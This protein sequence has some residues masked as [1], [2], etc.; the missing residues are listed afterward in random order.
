MENEVNEP[1]QDFEKLMNEYRLAVLACEDP[2]IASAEDHKPYQDREREA[3]KALTA[4]AS[5]APA[6]TDAEIMLRGA[7]AMIEAIERVIPRNDTDRDYA[8]TV[9]QHVESQA[10]F[11]NSA[12]GRILDLEE[13]IKGLRRAPNPDGVA[14]V[15]AVHRLLGSGS[16]EK[17]WPPGTPDWE[18]LESYVAA[19]IAAIPAPTAKEAPPGL[20]CKWSYDEN[21][22][23]DTECGHNFCFEEDGASENGAK[24][25]LYCGGALIEVNRS[26]AGPRITPEDWADLERAK[27]E[28]AE[29]RES[30]SD[31]I[32][33]FRR[34]VA[35]PQVEGE[36][37]FHLAELEA[38]RA[39]MCPD[40]CESRLK[41][42]EKHGPYCRVISKAIA[43]FQTA[44]AS[45]D[46][47]TGA[48][49]EPLPT[50]DGGPY[51]DELGA[52]TAAPG[53]PGFATWWESFNQWGNTYRYRAEEEEEYRNAAMAAWDAAS[54][55]RGAGIKPGLGKFCRRC[56]TKH[57]RVQIGPGSIT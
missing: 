41:N 45:P 9:R 21:G 16:D 39:E 13:E 43:F 37:A 19:L 53:R 8:D 10:A 15:D 33:E 6:P 46:S 56:V 7:N 22:P 48:D 32:P 55:A 34:P 2:E 38:I 54:M 3:R 24:F 57:T 35:G 51:H 42:S 49:T 20:T 50:A 4:F 11:L 28:M 14:L 36:K 40:H 44:A 31:L 26:V 18:A 25:C 5:Q 12:E 52:S 30:V 17:R 29:I 47:P 1:K 23:Y 27:T